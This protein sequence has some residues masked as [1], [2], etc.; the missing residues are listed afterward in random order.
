MVGFGRGCRRHLVRMD[1]AVAVRMKGL[2]SSL[3]TSMYFSIAAIRSGTEWKTPRRMALS[4]SSRNHCSPRFSQDEEVWVRC[5]C[6]R[7]CLGTHAPPAALNRLVGLH[8]QP[9]PD[10]SCRGHVHARR[11]AGPLSLPPGSP[12]YSR[13]RR[14]LSPH[15]VTGTGRDLPAGVSQQNDGT[16]P[17]AS[18][19]CRPDTHYKRGPCEGKG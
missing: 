18:K 9:Q 19:H 11:Q 15:L 8:C 4:V 17:D 12:R 7:G 3:W 6:N 16:Q 2:G 14:G 1:S 10:R 5:R 13:R